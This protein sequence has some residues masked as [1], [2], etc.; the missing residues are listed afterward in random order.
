[1]AVAQ[2]E[3][4]TGKRET[5]K[6]DIEK[7]VE[8]VKLIIQA[9]Q[10][11]W[12]H[13]SSSEL[14]PCPHRGATGYSVLKGLRKAPK[15]WDPPFQPSPFRFANGLESVVFSAFLIANPTRPALCQGSQIQLKK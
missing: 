3:R 7:F 15:S 6:L 12:P 2:N 11:I 8:N 1:M 4:A 14:L 10:N 5:R 13:E 9:A